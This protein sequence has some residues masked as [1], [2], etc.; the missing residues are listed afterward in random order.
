[1]EKVI[2]GCWDEAFDGSHEF[3]IGDFSMITLNGVEV[4]LDSSENNHPACKLIGAWTRSQLPI[5]LELASGIG[6][7]VF[8]LTDGVFLNA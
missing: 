6:V 5:L 3:V 2:K 8:D 7:K 1:M 4:E